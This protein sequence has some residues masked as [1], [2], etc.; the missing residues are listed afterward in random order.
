VCSVDPLSL[1][2]D[3]LSLLKYLPRPSSPSKKM[4]RGQSKPTATPR[5]ELSL[6]YQ[7]YLQRA[8]DAGQD[9]DAGEDAMEVGAQEAQ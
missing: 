7:E 4:R 1:L 2:N 9:A 6:T 3:P 5:G 8:V